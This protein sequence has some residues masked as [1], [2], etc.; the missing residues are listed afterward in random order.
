M[1]RPRFT[2]EETAE[3]I[4]ALAV[5]FQAGEFT[6]TVY[7]ASLFALHVKSWDIDD[8]VCRQLE[9]KHERSG[10][11]APRK[12]YSPQKNAYEK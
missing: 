8:I 12:S 1:T 7:R 3:R 10:G 9:I 11:L 2:P 5:R 4:D 6:E